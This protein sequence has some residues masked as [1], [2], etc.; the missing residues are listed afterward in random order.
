MP[1]VRGGDHIAVAHYQVRG[2][3]KKVRAANAAYR[4]E[5]AKRLWD[6]SEQL[7]GVHYEALSN[8]ANMAASV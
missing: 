3:P 2:Y 6:I 1:D 8:K 5:D 7:S 4:V